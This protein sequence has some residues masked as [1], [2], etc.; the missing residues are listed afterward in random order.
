MD[1][2]Q[3]GATPAEQEAIAKFIGF[4]ASELANNIFA[5]RAGTFRD[6]WE[7]LGHGLAAETTDAELQSLKRATQYAHYT[8]EYIVRAMWDAARILGFTE[9]FQ[10][11]TPEQRSEIKRSLAQIVEIVRTVESQTD[12][13]GGSQ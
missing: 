10:R 9:F 2:E 5:D 3:R 1:R 8:P 6:G 13:R 4:G 11:F 7:E 12:S